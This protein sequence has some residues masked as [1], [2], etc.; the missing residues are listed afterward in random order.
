VS[1]DAL[2]V[3]VPILEDIVGMDAAG[4]HQLFE[5]HGLLLQEWN[6]VRTDLL[7]IRETDSATSE[8]A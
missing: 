4:I 7:T 1:D 2:S 6:K 3:L 8:A 5:S